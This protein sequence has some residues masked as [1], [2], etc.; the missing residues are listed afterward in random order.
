MG[1][2]M[3]PTLA[4]YAIPSNSGVRNLG[5]LASA[6]TASAI[7]KIINVVAV[8]LIHIESSEDA[9]MNPNTNRRPPRPPTALTIDNA[10]RR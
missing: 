6:K 4:A 3:P 5:S 7:G 10:I 8:L 2:A 1:V 9:N